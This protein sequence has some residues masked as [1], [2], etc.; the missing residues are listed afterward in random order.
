L[1]LLVGKRAESGQRL[2]LLFVCVTAM[3]DGDLADTLAF[4]RP[5]RRGF[6]ESRFGDA[7]GHDEELFEQRATEL[8]QQRLAHLDRCH[9]HA[10]GAL[11]QR[12]LARVVSCAADRVQVAIDERQQQRDGGGQVGEQAVP[13][14]IDAVQVYYVDVKDLERIA[15]T[16][17]GELSDGKRKPVVDVGL[18][19][20]SRRRA[21]SITPAR[22]SL[23]LAAS[24]SPAL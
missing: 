1:L 8:G 20:G 7:I 9:A 21:V 11:D 19:E 24:R 15:Q 14:G 6:V 2:T 4:G 17:G 3:A 22:E 16:V 10:L 12:E 23:G 18:R 13:F 5:L